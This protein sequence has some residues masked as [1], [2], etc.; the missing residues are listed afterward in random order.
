MTS[1]CL[2]VT[3]GL[4]LSVAGAGCPSAPVTGSLTVTGTFTVNADGTY[5]DNTVTSGDEQFTLTPACLV[6]SSTPVT[7]DGAANI[8]KT[9]GYS[10]LT[11]TP[12]TGGGCTCS[13][14]VH[15]TGGL[16]LVS[17]APS[18]SG[19]YTTAGNLI[20]VSGDAGD[21]KY[22]Y[23]VSGDRLTVTPQSTSPTM[24]GTIVLQKGGSA[25][26]GGSGGTTGTGGRG[27]SSGT[28]G[29]GGSAGV[30]GIAGGG[31]GA[32]RGS[33]GASG[34]GG[35]RAAD[36]EAPAARRAQ[37]LAAQPALRE[38]PA[39]AASSGRA[40]STRTAEIPASPPTAP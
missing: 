38:P 17:V 30:G 27:G 1:S 37:A 11:C 29:A 14:T 39:R 15:Q 22:A 32:A 36:A 25:G 3:G 7:C 13:G 12:A 26:T 6:I 40:T 21:T 28:A 4:D 18:T 23:C 31:G 2:R 19:S 16:G 8:I 5:A 10:A 20:T 9:L 24:T 34:R 33:A 35:R